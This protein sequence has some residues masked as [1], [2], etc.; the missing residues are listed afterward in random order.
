L[1]DS[2]S[3]RFAAVETILFDYGNTLIEFGPRQLGVAVDAI[4]RWLSALGSVDREQLEAVRARQLRAPYANEYRE[5][6]RRE[7]CAE[8]LREVVGVDPTPDRIEALMRLRCE[9]FFECIEVDP[10]VPALLERL[11]DRY[12]LALVSNYPCGQ[13]IRDSLD[14]VGMSGL[15]DTVV[16][17]G[18]V[19]FCKPHPK[20]F[21]TALQTLDAG[22]R[23]ALYVGDNWLCDVQGAKR[24]GMRAVLVAQFAP[25]Q[26]LEPAPGDHE[27]DARIA[28]LSE[29][30]ALLP[31]R[32]A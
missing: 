5:N 30:E 17:S 26:R 1:T 6:D 20:P 19:G 4:E 21:E 28:H 13:C 25:Y 12:R 27:P 29:L 23:S 32:P 15:F 31:E 16:V 9:T 2:S 14:K 24:L 7:T 22:P 18:D 11:R 8:L 3:D 10:S